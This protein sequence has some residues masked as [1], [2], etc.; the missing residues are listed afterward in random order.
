[1]VSNTVEI[2]RFIKDEVVRGK[3]ITLYCL[4]LNEHTESKILRNTFFI[5]E[6]K[7][8]ASGKFVQNNW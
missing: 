3:I 1:M 2:R 5:S 8:T 6:F 7:T 4:F